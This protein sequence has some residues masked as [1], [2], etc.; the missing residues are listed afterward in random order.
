MGCGTGSI[1]GR[2]DIFGH[3]VWQATDR[4][5]GLGVSVLNT[6]HEVA[7]WIIDTTTIL[8]VY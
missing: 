7:V 3:F 5:V 2:K 6:N 4:L 8:N 1:P